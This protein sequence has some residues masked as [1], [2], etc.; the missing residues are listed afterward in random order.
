M[1]R[2][3]CPRAA[4]RSVRRSTGGELQLTWTETGGPEVKPR[5]TQGFGSVI[6]ERSIAHEL[7]GS[8]ELEF[9]PGGLRCH[10]RI[11]MR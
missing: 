6:V 1:A 4:S 8:A 7:G 9:D 3:R 2:C 5:V 11:P 10:I